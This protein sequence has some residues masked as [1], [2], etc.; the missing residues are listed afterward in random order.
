MIQSSKLQ[1]TFL[2][3]LFALGKDLSG[4]FRPT[5]IMVTRNQELADKTKKIS[6]IENGSIG[7]EV[8][9]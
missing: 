6:C 9:N 7:R 8:L 3:E 5:I 4:K 2:L 1:E